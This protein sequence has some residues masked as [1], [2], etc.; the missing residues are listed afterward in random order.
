MCLNPSFKLITSTYIAW[1]A[2]TLKCND[3]KIRSSNT[4]SR[5]RSIPIGTWLARWETTRN[6]LKLPARRNAAIT[7]GQV[8]QMFEIEWSTVGWVKNL[9]RLK[10]LKIVYVLSERKGVC[11][12]SAD[13]RS[14]A[15]D[16][17]DLVKE[18]KIQQHELYKQ[19]AGI[20]LRYQLEVKK[21][22]NLILQC[23]YKIT[24]Y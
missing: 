6:K 22:L 12:R 8:V 24:W 7:I 4:T 10:E 11:G 1:K 13:A 17:I 3:P 16:A 9:L 18:L 5:E 20:R 14:N 23:W 21:D 2:S 19:F 15:A